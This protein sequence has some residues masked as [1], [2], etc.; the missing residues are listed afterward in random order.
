MDVFGQVAAK[1]REIEEATKM[2][3]AKSFQENLNHEV[4]EKKVEKSFDDE[5]NEVHRELFGDDI[6]KA[7]YA[8][9]AQNRK[10]GRV[11]QEY[12][13][14]K[15]KKEDKSGEKNKWGKKIASEAYQ[16]QSYNTISKKLS[17]YLNGDDDSMEFLDSYW[18]S[19]NNGADEKKLQDGIKHAIHNLVSP[20]SKDA[21]DTFNQVMSAIKTAENDAKKE[22]YTKN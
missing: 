3:I 12:H 5:L 19:V 22:Y 2:N 6:E 7:V 1:R 16:K 20:G 14:G 9:T 15:G 17:K 4:E 8:D 13:R 21:K 18:K 10:L 11:G